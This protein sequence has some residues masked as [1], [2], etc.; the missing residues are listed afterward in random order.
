M[1]WLHGKNVWLLP[2][3]ETLCS[4]QIFF[5]INIKEYQGRL[6]DSDVSLLPLDNS[7]CIKM[8]NHY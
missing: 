4:K 3:Y 6:Q 5:K 2:E 7:L 1:G 8:N